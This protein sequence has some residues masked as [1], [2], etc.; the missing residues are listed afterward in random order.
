MTDLVLEWTPH[1][2]RSRKLVF[3]HQPDADCPL[4]RVEYERRDGHWRVVGC[5]CL[6]SVTLS[7]AD[8]EGIPVTYSDNQPA[9][10][11]ATTEVEDDD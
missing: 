8:G 11:P 5:E 9:S 1:G 10:R 7:S 3:E 2:G 4:A 6:E